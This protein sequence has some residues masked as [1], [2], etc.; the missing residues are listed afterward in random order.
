MQRLPERRPRELSECLS[1]DRHSG[2][3]CAL[4]P[5]AFVKSVSLSSFRSNSFGI[6]QTQV[7][8]AMD[9]SI[10]IAFAFVMPNSRYLLL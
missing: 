1:K 8:L 2:K 3:R 4:V 9:R 10:I 7:L 5:N 6:F